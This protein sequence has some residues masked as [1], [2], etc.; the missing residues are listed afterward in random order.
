MKIYNG[1]RFDKL[2]VPMEMNG[3]TLHFE[4]IFRSAFPKSTP[5]QAEIVLNSIRGCH[6]EAHGWVEIDAWL[7]KTST[8]YIAV[9]QHAQYR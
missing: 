8:G 6:D 1:E 3:K 2:N 5:S 4:E 9:R 7:E